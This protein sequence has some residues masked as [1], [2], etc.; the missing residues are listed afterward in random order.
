MCERDEWDSCDCDYSC[1]SVSASSRRTITT[2]M[3]EKEKGITG[4]ISA[5]ELGLRYRTLILIIYFKEQNKLQGAILNSPFSAQTGKSV[6]TSSK[7][8]QVNIIIE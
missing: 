8:M 4:Q 3:D 7:M 2:E 6:I 5:V 1:S